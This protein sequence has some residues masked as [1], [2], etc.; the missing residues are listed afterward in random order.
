MKRL[1]TTG[2]GWTVPPL[3]LAGSSLRTENTD[4]RNRALGLNIT[5]NHRR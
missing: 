4:E 1:V 3:L 5:L 2:L